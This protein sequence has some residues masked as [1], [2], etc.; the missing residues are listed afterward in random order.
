MHKL[1]QTQRVQAAIDQ[2]REKLKIFGKQHLSDAELLAIIIGSGTYGESALSICRRLL[3]DHHHRLTNI[4][5][6]S[7]MELAQSYR[8]L[9]MA[10]TMKILAAL[11]LGRRRREETPTQQMSITSSKDSFH[12][13]QPI[14]G[15]LPFEEFWAVMLNNANKIMHHECFGRGGVQ[16][17][18]VDLRRVIK[19]ALDYRATALIVGHNHPSGQMQPSQEDI[20]LTKNLKEA[21]GLFQIRLLDHL[22]VSD[23]AF[24]SFSDEG[25]I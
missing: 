22:I 3:H 1:T 10:K 4:G 13:L 7:F 18:Q 17:V 20:R 8:G 11:E 16:S 9:G 2:P 24:Y 6:R 21:A 12:F 23:D 15:E 19:T 25:L 5:C 14:L